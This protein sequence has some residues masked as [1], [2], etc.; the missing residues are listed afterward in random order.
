MDIKN[1]IALD[2]K[3]YMNTFGSRTPIA[4]THGS[5][6][7]LY[8]TAGKSYTDF[9]AGIAVNSLGY[10]DTG[11]TNAICEQ[12]TKLLHCSNI[13][14]I[15][16]QA[17]L[18]MLLH[19]LSGGYR[20]FFSNSGA[21]ANEGAI[22]LARKYFRDKGEEKYEIITFNNSFH[23]RTLATLA[24]TAQPKYQQPF[25]PL[26]QSFVHTPFGDAAAAE[27]AINSKTCAIMV[28]TIQG[29]GGVIMPPEGFI[30]SL[31]S[32][33]DRHGILLIID[34]VQTG[35]GRT[36]KMFSFEHE[37]IRPD[38][39]TIAKGMGGGV[40]IGALLAS[41]D[42]SAAFKPG[43]HGSTFG[44]N[45]LACAASAYVIS[46][47]EEMLPDIQ[48]KGE[49]LLKTLKQLQANKPD[50]VSSV[51]ALGLL[52]GIE[53]KDNLKATDIVTTAREKGFIIGTAANNTLRLAPPFI[54]SEEQIDALYTCLSGII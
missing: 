19:R 5:G 28:E 31:R 35:A 11:L 25:E 7:T 17:E 38:I 10:N 4:F 48:K 23:G 34:E 18:A 44:G 14:Y 2:S 51:R 22:K 20:V 16:R 54:I 13:Y 43:D 12:A 39:F 8:D 21:E 27:A 24:A 50:A 30:K 49:Y 46:R 29:E 40:P 32:I 15:E 45:P 26:P 36:G 1:I 3:A 52:A 6:C 47:I 41:E 33:C 53:L 9:F 42:V 37:G